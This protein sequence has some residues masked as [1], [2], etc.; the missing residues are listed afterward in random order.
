MFY[1]QAKERDCVEKVDIKCPDCG[2]LITKISS[3]SRATIFG[4][5]KLCK[6][7]KVIKYEGKSHRAV[8]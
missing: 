1:K 3:D 8:H 5:C 7:E 2:K 4:Y 6:K